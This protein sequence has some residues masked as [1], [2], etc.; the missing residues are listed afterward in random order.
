MWETPLRTEATAEALAPTTVAAAG[1][2]DAAGTVGLLLLVP[3]CPPCSKRA[4]DTN[5]ETM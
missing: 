2:V 1:T 4:R 3:Y 5:N